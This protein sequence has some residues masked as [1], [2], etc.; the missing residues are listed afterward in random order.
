MHKAYF[1]QM[2]AVTTTNF[3]TLSTSAMTLHEIMNTTTDSIHENITTVGTILDKRTT[4]ELFQNSTSPYNSEEPAYSQLNIVLPVVITTVF[5]VTIVV[6]VIL[7]L[8]LFLYRKRNRKLNS[9]VELDATY[10]TL[11]RGTKQQM[12]PQFLDASTGLYDQIQLSPSTGQSE[13]ISKTECPTNHTSLTSSHTHKKE[14]HHETEIET[15][16]SEYATYAVVDKRKTKKKSKNNKSSESQKNSV[17]GAVH[18]KESNKVEK[19]KDHQ[20][21]RKQNLEDM[22]AV[23][24]KKPKKHEEQVIGETAPP[25]PS[26]TI[27]SL[28]T[29]VQ[30]KPK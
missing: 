23:V 2:N 12:Q 21:E 18:S 16:K 29:A 1:V 13:V 4:E 25:V 9:T 26:H 11:D 15:S 24:Q 6:V 19:P 17:C 20:N 27:D 28:Y 3:D 22:Y 8:L 5:A 10:S 30:K 7:V 14:E